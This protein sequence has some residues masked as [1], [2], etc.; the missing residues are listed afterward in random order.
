[1]KRGQAGI[2]LKIQATEHRY[3][4][5]AKHY[6]EC[7][8]VWVY[9]CYRKVRKGRWLDEEGRV[10]VTVT[11]RRKVTDSS[12]ILPYLSLSLLSV[13]LV[14]ESVG[15]LHKYLANLV[16]ARYHA[17][18]S[19]HLQV[20]LWMHIQSVHK[21]TCEILYPP[22]LN[23]FKQSLHIWMVQEQKASMSRSFSIQNQRL[24]KQ[25]SVNT[26]AYSVKPSKHYARFV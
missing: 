13:D 10:T 4:R 9:W 11:L 22:S 26:D 18:P 3:T 8:N 17:I 12:C 19:S 5:R 1:M 20:I 6:I 23:T 15:K 14:Y 7:V 16:A 2:C 25:S 21:D 24:A